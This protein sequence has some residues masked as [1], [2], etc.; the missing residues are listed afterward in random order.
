MFETN[1]FFIN[2]SSFILA[3]VCN[4]KRKKIINTKLIIV[5]SPRMDSCV[6]ICY[7]E[8]EHCRM[9][10]RRAASVKEVLEAAD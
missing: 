1:I 4:A 5:S 2:S 6:S 3:K 8:E 9:G 7:Q 10:C